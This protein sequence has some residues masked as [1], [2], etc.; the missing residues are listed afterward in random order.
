MWEHRSDDDV[1]RKGTKIVQGMTIGDRGNKEKLQAW[2]TVGAWA[3]LSYVTA[4][5]QQNE[6]GV[7]EV[8]RVDG[9]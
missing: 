6:G 4:G 5:E 8:A 1:L 9:R 3:S 7:H 2:S